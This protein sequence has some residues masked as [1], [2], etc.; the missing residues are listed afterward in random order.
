MNIYY[1]IH[2]YTK[3]KEMNKNILKEVSIFISVALACGVTGNI[4]GL[5]IVN[6]IKSFG[7]ESLTKLF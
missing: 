5:A 6:L 1:I 4:I 2:I 3:G 7:T